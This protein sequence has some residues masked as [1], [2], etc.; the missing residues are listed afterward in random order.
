MC[1]NGFHPLCFSPI[2]N[3]SAHREGLCWLQARPHV[4]RPHPRGC[5]MQTAAGSAQGRQAPGRSPGFAE[6]VSDTPYR[7]EAMCTFRGAY[8]GTQESPIPTPVRGTARAMCIPTPA[9]RPVR[10]C[11]RGEPTTTEERRPHVIKKACLGQW[12]LG[13]S[14][15][16]GNKLQAPGPVWHRHEPPSNP[17]LS[18][19]PSKSSIS[20]MVF[21]RCLTRLAPRTLH[22]DSSQ[23]ETNPRGETIGSDTRLG[24]QQTAPSLGHDLGTQSHL[25]WPRDTDGTP[26]DESSTRGCIMALASP[27]RTLCRLLIRPSNKDTVRLRLASNSPRHRRPRR[28]I[29]ALNLFSE[30]LLKPSSFSVVRNILRLLPRN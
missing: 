1:A 16:N 17:R 6:G 12:H 24:P 20:G 7:V 4:R 27:I 23:Y 3:P 11:L 25:V 26:S 15:Q 2:R 21:G 14:I 18:P 5:R 13:L 10:R 8:W 30:A 29:L 28:L 9:V 22:E 19:Q